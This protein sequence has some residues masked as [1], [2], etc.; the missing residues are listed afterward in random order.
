MGFRDGAFA[1]VWE[2]TEERNNFAKVRIST[3]RK[4]KKTEEYITDFSGFV[5][6]VGNAFKKIDDI[7]DTL[8]DHGRCRIKLSACDVSSRYDKAAGREYINFTVFDFTFPQ[9]NGSGDDNKSSGKKA[10][11]AKTACKTKT[12]PPPLEDDDETNDEESVPF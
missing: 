10:D 1:T 4:D 5:S 12:S 3:R 6:F 8:G 9:E 11:N 7:R 2:I